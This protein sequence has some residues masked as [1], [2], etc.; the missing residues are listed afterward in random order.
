MLMGHCEIS[1]E[2]NITFEGGHL[3]TINLFLNF[4]LFFHTFIHVDSEI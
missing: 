3:G 2:M 4:S 1:K